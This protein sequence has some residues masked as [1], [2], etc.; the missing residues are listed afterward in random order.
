MLD[1][2]AVRMI[3]TVFS[4]LAPLSFCF[5]FSEKKRTAKLH[6]YLKKKKKKERNELYVGQ[7]GLSS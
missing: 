4:R 2:K 7:I 1:V 5:S 6:C 3:E